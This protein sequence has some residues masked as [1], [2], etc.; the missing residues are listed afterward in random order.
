MNNLHV[1]FESVS[2]SQ[3]ISAQNHNHTR[4]A[5]YSILNIPLKLLQGDNKLY[6]VIPSLCY[7]DTKTQ[8]HNK[9]L[10]NLR[11]VFFIFCLIWF[12]KNKDFHENLSINININNMT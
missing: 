4:K 3:G 10:Q 7:Q 5:T 1:T 11:L 12:Q 2:Y 8:L 9:Q 6:V